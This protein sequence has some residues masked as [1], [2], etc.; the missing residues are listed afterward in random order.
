MRWD[1]RLGEHG[2]H[3]VLSTDRALPWIFDNRHLRR[4]PYTL[5]DLLHRASPGFRLRFAQSIARRNRGRVPFEL[6]APA[7][8]YYELLEDLAA[9]DGLIEIRD[10]NR[11]SLLVQYGPLFEPLRLASA[12]ATILWRALYPE[13]S[14]ELSPASDFGRGGHLVLDS[15]C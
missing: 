5:S 12:I 6:V 3:F 15:S 13:E 9:L 10:Q 2:F 11:Y 14:L 4:S 8:T 7:R 1:L